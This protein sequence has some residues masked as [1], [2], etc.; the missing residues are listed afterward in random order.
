M[1]LPLIAVLA[2]TAAVLVYGLWAWERIVA[3]RR[4]QLPGST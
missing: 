2:A 1:M 3:R 4:E